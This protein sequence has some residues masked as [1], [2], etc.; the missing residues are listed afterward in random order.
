LDAEPTRTPFANLR[1]VI[2]QGAEINKRKNIPLLVSIA[3]VCGME[4]RLQKELLDDLNYLNIADRSRD[5]IPY[6]KKRDEDQ[7]SQC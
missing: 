1:Y 7:E 6:G 5:G 3:I 2:K 4:C